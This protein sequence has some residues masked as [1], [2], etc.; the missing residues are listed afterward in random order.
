MARVIFYEK[1]GQGDLLGRDFIAA[2]RIDPA[3]LAKATP[4][5]TADYYICGPKGFMA[6]MISGLKAAQ[7]PDA[8]IHYEFFG[9]AEAEL[10]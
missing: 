9:P 2:G 5:A 3:W 10:L 6:E 4:V 1:P 7:V 8:R